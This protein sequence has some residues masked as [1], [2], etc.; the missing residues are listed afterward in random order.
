MYC[1]DKLLFNLN[2]ILMNIHQS[3]VNQH[4]FECSSTEKGKVE[5]SECW[6][7]MC[8]I[9]Q[10]QLFPKQNKNKR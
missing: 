8:T 1:S 2:Y 10:H 7:K 9:A 6:N 3:T 4:E 5:G